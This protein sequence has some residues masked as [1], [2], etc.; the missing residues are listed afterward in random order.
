MIIIKKSSEVHH[1]WEQKYGNYKKYIMY[2]D[3]YI[4]LLL[5]DMIKLN[6]H[7]FL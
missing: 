7:N 2:D 3:D 6:G 4:Y 5:I 1:F